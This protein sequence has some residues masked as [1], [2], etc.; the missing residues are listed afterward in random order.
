MRMVNWCLRRIGW[1]GVSSERFRSLLIAILLAPSIH[2]QSG[3]RFAYT[4]DDLLRSQAN[5]NYAHFGGFSANL[6]IQE[7]RII[8]PFVASLFY[9][10]NY[11]VR[12]GN[13]A[14]NLGLGV[15][16][17]IFLN[18]FFMGRV[19]GTADLLLFNEANNKPDPGFGL[20]IGAGYSALGSTFDH[21]EH[22]PI[23]RAGFSFSNI[24]VTYAYGLKP[25]ILVNHQLAIGVKFDW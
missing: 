15:V 8:H 18:V 21:T 11:M 25:E 3:N 13:E 16:P 19:T 1:P 10:M 14:I 20:R 17:E 23:A 5:V 22:T 12:P 24:R 6:A 2:A 7:D 9:E 4:G